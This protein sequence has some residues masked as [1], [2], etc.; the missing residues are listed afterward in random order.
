MKQLFEEF[1]QKPFE[2][3]L[4]STIGFGLFY[5]P[6]TFAAAF[7]PGWLVAGTWQTTIIAGS[8][9][10]PFFTYKFKTDD[11]Y[12]LRKEKIPFRELRYSSI[13]LL[14]VII[15]Q[16]QQATQVNSS[17][18]ILSTLPVLI[19][20]FAYPLGNRKMM[21]LCDGRLDTFQRVLG[22]TLASM[23]FWIV[24]S[25][26]GLFLHGAPSQDQLFQSFLVAICAGI[27]ATVLFFY[28]TDLA[29]KSSQQMAAVESTQSGEIVFAVFG[30]VL[31]LG[32]YM[33]SGLALLG[34]SLIVLGMILH[35]LSS[36]KVQMK[37]D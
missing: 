34:L 8:L 2:W 33:P 26:I 22:M 28:A 13:I 5:A 20:A 11:G 36:Q 23:P 10:V 37:S 6:I 15:I 25:F 1:K 31:L 3:I 32:A 9:L 27:I 35:S 17:A 24:L 12:I 16:V 19:A 30:E 7:G 18:I 14:G 29:R 4:W 21:A